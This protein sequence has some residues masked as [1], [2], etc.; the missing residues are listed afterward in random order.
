[1]KLP[2]SLA[3]LLFALL[4]ALPLAAQ[5]RTS[6]DYGLVAQEIAPGTYVI[7][8]LREDFSFANGGNIVNTGFLVGRSG[9]IVIDTGPSR[10][11]GEQMLA[12]IRAITPLPVVL[13]LNTHHHPDHFLGNQAF[14]QDTLAALPDTIAGIRSEGEGF[15]DNMYRLNGDWMRDT[16][17]VVPAR[18]VMPGRQDIAGR[19]VELLALGG[20]TAADLVVVDHDSGTVYA[21]DLLFNGRAP[22]TPHA[23]IA[24][25]LGALEALARLPARLWVPGHGEVSTR[26]DPLHETRDYLEWLQAT[27]RDAAEAGLDMTEVFALDIP[28]RFSRLALVETEFRRSVV[29]L[30]PAAEQAALARAQRD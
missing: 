3:S 9:V 30:F 27:I 18:A 22:T 10:R 6:F 7:V 28:A 5:Q 29:H 11:Y 8:G 16:E 2:L 15:N 20:H 12:A 24:R 1:M 14:P 17:V 19:D 4:L 26:L 13:T 21:A 23:D 25:W